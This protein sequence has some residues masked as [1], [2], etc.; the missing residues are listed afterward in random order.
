MTDKTTDIPIARVID[1][2][3]AAQ[4]RLTAAW[5]DGVPLTPEQIK[6]EQIRDGARAALLSLFERSGRNA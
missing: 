6:D 2:M 5:K 1:E 3:L 4:S